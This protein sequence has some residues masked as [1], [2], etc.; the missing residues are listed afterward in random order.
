MAARPASPVDVYEYLDYR[1]LLRDYYLAK[2]AQGR[3]FSYRAFARRAGLRAPNDLKRVSEGERNLTSS[4][5]G[6]YAEA[7]GLSGEEAAYFCDL[8]TFNQATTSRERNAAYERLRGFRG[9]R[10]AH[11]LELAHAAYHST[12]FVPAIR[13]M[14]L[15]HDFRPDPVWIAKRLIPPISVADARRALALLVELQMIATDES[16]TV[17]Q[18]DAVVTTGPQTTGLHIANYH[19]SMMSRAAEAIDLIPASDRDVS[20]ITFAVGEDGMRRIKKRVQRFRQELIALLAEE[21]DATQVLQLNMQ[22]FP[23]AS[24]ETP[25][26]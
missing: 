5:A 17:K 6:R 1:A 13:E 8:V 15:L 3:G 24:E 2:K 22:L 4:M 16:G 19:R 21:Q 18:T 20:S 26:K 14:V 10:A 12:W 9:Y 7:M 23:L 25:A 11:K